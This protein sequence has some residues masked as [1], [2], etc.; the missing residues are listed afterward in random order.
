MNTK[1]TLASA[2]AA[3]L[4]GAST[5][6]SASCT[7][8]S[9]LIANCGFESGDFTSWVVAGTDTTTI[10]GQQYYGVEGFD[11]FPVATGGTAPNSGNDQAFVSDPSN[12]LTLSQ[13]FATT[14]GA[15]YTVSFYMATATV[16]GDTLLTN[17]LTA[18]FGTSTLAS[19]SAVADSSYKLYTYDV[20]ATA[21]STT[22]SLAMTNLTGEFILDDFS[23]TKDAVVAVPETSTTV[24][25]GA[26]LL[27][28]GFAARRKR[29]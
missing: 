16:D 25:M 18:K 22:F 10:Q 3:L 14:V 13:T 2:A 24:L 26:G 29:Q 15:T 7:S 28:L 23:V 21:A 27:A 8:A 6:A 12:P 5:A 19:L 9:N 20:A 11:P 1:L 17:A 4:F